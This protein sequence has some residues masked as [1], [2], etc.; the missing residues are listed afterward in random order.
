MIGVAATLALL[1]SCGIPVY[2]DSGDC[3]YGYYYGLDAFDVCYSR[4][5]S[6]GPR[7][8]KYTC[9]DEGSAVYR[10]YYFDDSNCSGSSMYTSNYTSYFDYFVCANNDDEETYDSD[11]FAEE[12]EIYGYIW[13][14]FNASDKTLDDYYSST[15]SYI[16]CDEEYISINLSN[17]TIDEDCYNYSNWDYD[18]IYMNWTYYCGDVYVGPGANS[19]NNSCSEDYDYYF[20]WNSIGYAYKYGYYYLE[21]NCTNVTVNSYYGDCDSDSIESNE[22]FNIYNYT[23]AKDYYVLDVCDD[24]DMYTCDDN[25]NLIKYY[26][27]D[28]DCS[29]SYWYASNVSDDECY[30]SSGYLRITYSSACDTGDDDDDD[31]TTT[32]AT[33]MTTDGS[34][35]GDDDAGARFGNKLIAYCCA[36]IAFVFRLF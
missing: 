8:W 13:D 36:L 27:W 28:D 9:N 18:C 4:I 25:G 20:D 11:C 34:G 6:W 12:Y 17:I 14:G 15:Y 33:P 21:S 16:D 26:Y 32:T 3:G 2:G 22:N 1:I 10:T 31:E 24:G 7:S 23:Q 29:G 30:V 19:S 35:D 5:Y